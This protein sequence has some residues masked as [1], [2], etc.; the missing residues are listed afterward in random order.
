MERANTLNRALAIRLLSAA[1]M[2]SA[3]ASVATP[4]AAATSS[5]LRPRVTTNRGCLET[6]DA[7][8]FA[9]GERVAIFLSIGSSTFGQANATLFSIKPSGSVSVFSFGTLFTNVTYGFSARVGLPVGIH[10]LQLK[11]S[12]GGLTSRSSCSF[13]VVMSMTT[14][15]PQPSASATRTPTP[16]K[17]PTT[18]T[19]PSTA[20]RPRVR[21]N[22]GC[23]ETGEDPTFYVGE[24]IIVS[25]G[26][27]SDAVPFAQATLF[28]TLPNGFVNVLRNRIITTNQTFSFKATVAPPTGVE[29]LRLRAA[30]SGLKTVSS[31]CSFSVA[32]FPVRTRTRTGTAT[33]TRTPTPTPTPP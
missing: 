29:V 10:E 19:T 16:T 21:T 15:T 12:A 28:D 7:A 9:V 5:V 13:N 4:S 8:T 33:P 23:A 2:I 18:A 30:A 24:S 14:Q 26:I 1:A 17:T 3:L 11:A 25:Y 32:Y 31:T 22:R 20:L 6:G 27:E